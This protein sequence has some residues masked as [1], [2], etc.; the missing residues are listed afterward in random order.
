[1]TES[2]EAIAD[3]VARLERRVS[4]VIFEAVREQLRSGDEGAKELERRLS[5]VRRSLQKAEAILRR[6]DDD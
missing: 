2:F 6:E 4:D 1:L 5:R 3:D